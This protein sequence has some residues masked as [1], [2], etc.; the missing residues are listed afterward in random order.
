[1]PDNATP[2][3]IDYRIYIG[4]LFFRWKI[5]VLCFL[6]CLLGGVLYLNVAPKKYLSDCKV[7]VYRDP[8]LVISNANSPWSSQSSHT[9]LFQ[10]GKLRQR[11]V[12]RLM[13]IWGER[14]GSVGKMML[15]V[16]VGQV[17]SLGPTMYISVTSD[18]ITYGGAF[19]SAL[20]EEHKKEWQS[21]QA[22]A[23]DS[24]TSILTQELEDL[25]EH[26]RS[27]E[28]ALIEY[29]RLHDM[30]RVDARSS[31]ESR[32]LGALVNQRHS[33]QTELMMLEQQFPSLKDANVGVL[34][35]VADLSKETG[36]I[37]PLPDIDEKGT[38]EAEPAVDLPE[39]LVPRSA[40][41]AANGD[42]H[43][44]PSLR[45]K[46]IRLEQRERELAKSLKPEHPTL[47]VLR[48]DIE[49]ARNDLEVAA[50][51]KMQSIQDRHR[52]LTIAL[53]S[54]ESAEYKWQAKNLL[55]RQRRAEYKRISSVVDRFE[56]NYHMLY[57]RLHDMRVS[58]EL[59]AEHFRIVE[60]VK[61][62]PNPFWPDP[63]KILLIALALGL[64]SGFG[65]A[66]LMQVTDNKIQSINDVERELGVPFLGGVPYW[67]HSGLERAIRPI[68]TEENASGA[69][70][71]YRAL[72]TSLL[73]A[74]G[75]I[76]EKIVLVTSA[77]AREGK[78]LT[79]LNIA[80]MIA[81]MG[82]K[83]LLVDMDLRRGRLHRSLGSSRDPGI[84]DVLGDRSALKEVVQK[85][86]IDNLHL[87]STGGPVDNSSE[88]LQSSDLIGLFGEIQED[89]DYIMIDTS[90]V[91]RVTDTVVAASQGLGVV[92]YVARV[93]R[94]S[95]PMI[96]YSLD[97]LKD[98]R[99]MGMIMNS[100]EMHR[101]S[102][103][104]YAYQY[105]NYAYYSNAYVYGYN[106]HHDD[107]VLDQGAR[108]SGIGE[109]WH[110]RAQELGQWLRQVLGR[111]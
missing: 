81:Q 52:A 83:V 21:V 99:V 1:M 69:I 56:Q 32:Y 41:D 35:D 36:A 77:D 50:Q 34:S 19:L 66:L 90:P 25:E 86:R 105:P 101:L 70:E 4:I 43:G 97:M 48:D 96:Q 51:T 63:M 98:A 23:V 15:P 87:V 64:G 95:K 12:D 94:T 84:T 73:G 37:K 67:A 103:L 65:I 26:I 100:I 71:A 57:S 74:L 58:E 49:R 44:W 29:Q 93:N 104:Y 45:V 88:L 82:K 24:A 109:F 39:E 55:A 91:L 80:I 72:R 11:V 13:P 22:E 92:V 89:F 102:S 68:V 46:L 76:N 54:V 18:H 38:V 107:G 10:S 106:Y 111:G 31:V 60:P 40:E 5:I 16:S 47:K 33:L 61:A 20:I 59:K 53:K 28:D 6:Y 30:A 17:R 62:Y 7:M 110:R 27:A 75:K 3:K 42:G 2:Q 79:T 78:T 8:K 85:T 108:G 14:V 9:Y